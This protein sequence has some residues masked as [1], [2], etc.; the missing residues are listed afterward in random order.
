MA[1]TSLSVLLYI[2]V[3]YGTSVVYSI[4]LQQFL[5]LADSPTDDTHPAY[6]WR[7]LVTCVFVVTLQAACCS[8]LDGSAL[9][10]QHLLSAQQRPQ[11]DYA[12]VASSDPSASADSRPTAKFLTAADGADGASSSAEN[13]TD[14]EEGEEER[15]AVHRTVERQVC[16]SPGPIH[17]LSLDDA[18]TDIDEPLSL[19]PSTAASTSRSLWPSSSVFTSRTMIL[20]AYSGFASLLQTSS[21]QL[22]GILCFNSVRAVEPAMAASYARVA[23]GDRLGWTSV[24]GLLMVTAACVATLSDKA[25]CSVLGS[26]S[27][28]VAVAVLCGLLI[29]CCMIGRNSL[30]QMLR[31]TDAEKYRQSRLQESATYYLQL[32]AI[33]LLLS[34]VACSTVLGRELYSE[35]L[36]SPS[37]LALVL[38]SS[39]MF[40]AYNHCSLLVCERVDLVTHSILTIFKRPVLI[41][42]STLYLERRVSHTALVVCLFITLGLVLHM[43]GRAG[44]EKGKDGK[45]HETSGSNVV[46]AA[47]AAVL[48]STPALS[49]FFL[50]SLPQYI[51]L[52]PVVE[53]HC[54]DGEGAARDDEWVDDRRPS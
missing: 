1:L 6:E 46:V 16:P 45:L 3:W 41:L 24:L 4:Q 52:Q 32:L 2:A 12:L 26:D 42:A 19:P 18:D 28:R 9:Y 5:A 39:A 14:V 23:Q 35:W 36:F 21:L 27:G 13:D 53:Q 40:A 22:S 30:V 49:S 20:T 33:M 34:A 38:S 11:H 44:A 25:A 50:H 8:L 47:V 31:V 43:R 7:V 10:I 37:T 15:T 54:S 17:F 29:N 51:A 48:A